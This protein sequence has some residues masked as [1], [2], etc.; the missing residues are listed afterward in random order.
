MYKI[1]VIIPCYNQGKYINEAVTSVLSQTYQDVEIIIV[2]DGSTDDYTIK[3]LK[4]YNRPN[5]KILHTTNQGLASARNNG[6]KEAIGKYILPLDADDKIE[7][8][9]LEKAVKILDEH[10]DTGI[11]YC[12]AQYFGASNEIWGL[13]DY[14]PEKMLLDNIIFCSGFFRK[15]DWETVGGY[16]PNMKYGWEDWDFWLSLIEL[17]RNVYKIPEILFYYRI[18][19]DSMVRMMT[20]EQKLDSF[21]HIFNN[22]KNLYS[23]NINHIFKSYINIK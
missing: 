11:V 1:S 8:T 20:E 19:E 10:P 17:G 13:P 3:L 22:H 5:T 7:P 16:N 21:V 14:S 23:N 9:Y 18:K 4:N 6:I 12:H 15:K 2:N